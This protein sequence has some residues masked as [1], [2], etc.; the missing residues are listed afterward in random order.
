MWAM[1]NQMGHPTPSH[2]LVPVDCDRCPQRIVES[3]SRQQPAMWAE[4]YPVYYSGTMNWGQRP[5]AGTKTPGDLSYSTAQWFAIG[6]VHTNYY[7]F[8][9]RRRIPTSTPLSR[10]IAHWP[11]VVCVCPGRHQLWPACQR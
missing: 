10:S 9:V 5:A 7:M 1:C 4:N 2:I 11:D 3:R 8:F 6:G